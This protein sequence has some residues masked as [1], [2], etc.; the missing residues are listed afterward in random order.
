MQEW[1]PITAGWMP[2]GTYGAGLIYSAGNVKGGL[3]FKTKKRCAEPLCQCHLLTGC[4]T[5]ITLIGHPG[6]VILTSLSPLLS[7]SLFSRILFYSYLPCRIDWGSAIPSPGW[8]PRYNVSIALAVNALT[9]MN[10]SM[11]LRDNENF[12]NPAVCRTM[13]MLLPYLDPNIP[14]IVC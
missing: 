5:N 10:Y 8:L 12:F 2:G 4:M 7:P 13:A 6:S 3:A 9:G 1:H 11:T 14:P